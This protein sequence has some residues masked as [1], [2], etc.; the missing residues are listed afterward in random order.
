VVAEDAVFHN[1]CHEIGMPPAGGIT[2][3]LPLYVGFGVANRIL[4]QSPVVEAAAA[5]EMGIVDHVVPAEQFEEG[6]LAATRRLTA[7]PPEVTAAI[8]DLMNV[9]LGELDAHFGA[10]GAALERA[11][12]HLNG[13]RLR[14]RE[15]GAGG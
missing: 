4:M 9:H 12:S 11:V 7:L 15:G 6:A 3:L 14:R 5:L 13:Q 8:K 1:R 10:E 2:C